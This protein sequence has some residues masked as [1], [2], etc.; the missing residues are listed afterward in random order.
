MIAIA[1][2]AHHGRA[3]LGQLRA[4]LPAEGEVEQQGERDEEIR[5]ALRMAHEL[6]M[7]FLSNDY[8]KGRYR[9]M[10][11]LFDGRARRGGRDTL[12]FTSLAHERLYE[13]ALES[14]QVIIHYQRGGG[15]DDLR[16]VRPDAPREDRSSTTSPTT[17][18]TRR[19][20]ARTFRG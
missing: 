13:N 9:E 8:D 15:Q 14:D 4:Q 1:I 17:A 7:A 10:L 19:C 3:H 16:P 5:G 18:A 6:S 20:S 2:M 12:T 11:T